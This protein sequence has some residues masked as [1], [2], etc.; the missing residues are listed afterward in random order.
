MEINAIAIKTNKKE[1]LDLFE[2]HAGR[3]DLL[4][5]QQK[6]FVRLFMSGQKFRT[7]AKTAGVHEATIA[8]RL[9]RIALRISSNHFI[10]ALA[11]TSDASS[12]YPEKIKIVKDHFLNGLSAKAI[13][14]NIGMS[15]YK[16]RKII[17]QMRNI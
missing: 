7:I 10:S 3:I 13:S 9:K 2:K 14:K 17:R 8:R 15:P 5:E 16:V 11:V 4:G 1:L 6:T 12:G